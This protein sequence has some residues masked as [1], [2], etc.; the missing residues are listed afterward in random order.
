MGPLERSLGEEHPVIRDNANVVAR[1]PRKAA[2]ERAAVASLEFLELASIH[3]SGDD[4]V[5]IEGEP[6]IAGNHAVQFMCRVARLLD[7]SPPHSGTPRERID[8]R[9][10]DLQR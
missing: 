6:R 4:L 5:W 8:N 9:A 2:R 3:H 7:L 1:P 10:A